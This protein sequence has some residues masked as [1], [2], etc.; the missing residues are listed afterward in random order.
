MKTTLKSTFA[1]GA[2][3]AFMVMLG[4]EAEAEP[5]FSSWYGPG[6][7]G[8][9]TASGEVFRAAAHTAA[10]PSL[11]FGTQ[12]LVSYGGRRVIVE[13][14]DRG[15]YAGDRGLDLS[16]AAAERIGLTAVGVDAVDV[17]ILA[18]SGGNGRSA[19]GGDRDGCAA[20]L[21]ARPYLKVLG[22]WH[23]EGVCGRRS[24]PDE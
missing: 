1:A 13:V 11:P 6:F 5:V 24:G 12:L 8:G 10:H 21:F 3:A 23:P 15:P 19:S 7:E 22:A 9:A 2:T 16:Q 20:L 4:G 14:N 17:R 18:G